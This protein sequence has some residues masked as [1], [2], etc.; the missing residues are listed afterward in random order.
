MLLAD[1]LNEWYHA[2]LI[3]ALASSGRRNESLIAYQDLRRTL[4]AELGLEPSQMLRELHQEV[5]AGRD[6]WADWG[7]SERSRARQ[8]TR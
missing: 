3:K 6:S 2:Q 1:P 8:V 5:L 7:M 4:S